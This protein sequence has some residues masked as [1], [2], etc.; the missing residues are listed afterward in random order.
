[1]KANSGGLFEGMGGLDLNPFDGDGIDFDF[2]N[3]YSK[4]GNCPWLFSPA[5]IREI[6]RKNYDQN[7]RMSSYQI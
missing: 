7:D 6:F 2:N 3:S 5:K 1:M 4:A